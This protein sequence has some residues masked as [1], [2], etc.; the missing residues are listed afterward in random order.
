ML[1][2][3]LNYISQPLIQN[4]SFTNKIIFKHRTNRFYSLLSISFWFTSIRKGLTATSER[5]PDNR[6]RFTSNNIANPASSGCL[7]SYRE[8]N[9]VDSE[10]NTARSKESKNNCFQ[11]LF[12]RKRLFC[13]FLSFGNQ[14]NYIFELISNNWYLN[15]L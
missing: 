1:Y 13:Y 15:K 9:P 14:Q 6:K 8:R 3:I 2:E 12:K 4:F 7:I 5:N 10:R 11:P